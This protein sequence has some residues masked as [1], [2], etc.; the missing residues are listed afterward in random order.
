MHIQALTH[1]A[2]EDPAGIGEWAAA[3]GHTLALTPLF[4]GA[5]LPNLNTFD[6]LVVMGGPMGVYDDAK[7]AWLTAEKNFIQSAIAANKTVLGVC[8]G[9]QLIAT[10]LGAQV[11]R[12]AHQEIGW[13]PLELTAAGQH[14]PLLAG[15]T[16]QQ[17]V[18]HWHGDT[19]SLPSG[20]I[21]LASSAAC[22]QQIFLY[23]ERVLGLQ[24]HIEATATSVAAI[25]AHC[26]DEL[27][28]D[29]PFIQPSAQLL[30]VDAAEYRTLQTV[31]F[32]LL[33]QLA[34]VH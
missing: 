17:R 1:V 33:D 20:A 8:L 18:F 10:V 11:T 27:I 26:A 2:F 13:F 32:T 9:A 28:P 34:L 31:L 24:C 5:A 12:N 23:G 16:P 14:S 29:A 7:Y 30:T 15:L 25:V 3:R 19:F 21:Q 22:A 4:A 6:W